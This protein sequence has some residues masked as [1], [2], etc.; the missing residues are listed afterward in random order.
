MLCSARRMPIA[1]LPILNGK[2]YAVWDANLIQ[3][4]LRNKHMSFVPFAVEFARRELDYT[5]EHE[6]IVK[7]TGLMGEFFEAVHAGMSTQNT[8]RMNVVALKYV[9]E[10]YDAIGPDDELVIPNLFIW[11][12]D[13]MTMATCEAL[14]GPDNPMRTQPQLL[15]DIWYAC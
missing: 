1:T 6:R 9:A 13:L 11:A 15:E 4:V 14:Y 3:A 7:E 5:D 2:M 10:R 12:R 8:N